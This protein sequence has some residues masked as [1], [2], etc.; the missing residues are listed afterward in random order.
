[1]MQNGV[2]RFVLCI[3]CYPLNCQNSDTQSKF[4][5]VRVYYD[6]VC[7]VSAEWGPHCSNAAHP[8]VKIAYESFTSS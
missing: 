8:R 7:L 4:F 1:M 5:V 2:N 6:A 3:S